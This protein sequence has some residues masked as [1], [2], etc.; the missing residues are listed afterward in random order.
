MNNLEKAT[1]K[2]LNA[3]IIPTPVKARYL[4]NESNLIKAKMVYF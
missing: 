1:N 4:K 3:V 2:R